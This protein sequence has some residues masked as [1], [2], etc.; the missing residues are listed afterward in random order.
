M[1]QMKKSRSVKL[2][3]LEVFRSPSPWRSLS[4][5]SKPPPLD[6]P[7]TEASSQKY[8][9][10]VRRLHN[11]MK[12]T[13]SSDAKKGLLPVSIQNTQSGSDGKNLPQKCLSNSSVSSKKPSKTL[14]RSSTLKPCS[15]YPIKSTIAVK[16][17]DVNPQEKATCSSTLK[18]SKFPTYLMLNPGGTESEGTSVM[19][20]CRYT[21]CSLNSHHHARLPQLNSFMSAR[22]RLLE[23]QKSVKLEAPKRLKV[24]CETK[25]ASDIDQVAFD[26]ELASDEADRGNPTP[27]LREIDMGFFIEIYAKEKQQAGRIGRFESVKHGEDQEDIMFAIE[28]NGKAAE[29]DGVKQAIPSVPH[30]LPKSETSIEED[31]KNYFDVAAIEE[32]AK[33]SLHQKQNAEVADKNHSP[34]WFHEE[35][36]MGSYFSEVS[37]DGEYMENIEL[38]DSD[39]QDTDMNW[40]EEQFSACDYKQEIDS[41][42]IMQKTGSKFEASSESLCGISEMWLD[43]I[44][45]NHYADILVEVAL[46]AVKEEK[47]THFE[48][49][50][51]GTK[52]V[53][54]DIEFNTQETDHLSN[55]ASHEHDQSSTEEVFEH[56]TNTRDNNRESEKHMDNEVS[57]ASKVLDEDAI[58][59]CEGHTNSETFAI[60]ESCEDSNPSLEI[61]DEGLSQENLINL[62]AEPKESSIIIQDQELLEE[63]QVRVS[64]FHTSCV[65]SE[66]QNTGKNWKWAV[67]HKRPDQDNEEVRRIN[68][69]KPNFLPLNPDPEPEK[70]DLKHQMIDERKHADEWM[71]DFA[72]RQAVTKLVPAG[73]MKVALLVE[74]FETVMS[75]PK[76]EAHIRNNS[77]FVHV[78]PIQA[79]S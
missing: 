77:P 43:D 35:I 4:Q 39:S 75:I 45:S 40:E 62:S 13:C 44:L 54:E 49:Q 37:Y 58:E 5:P 34:S 32:D 73:K 65:D 6:V 64:R 18:D 36:C 78:R 7:A 60:D 74:A 22:R 26:G 14:T 47:N 33:G 23:T 57:C 28:E 56:F 55:A 27:L 17:E 12:P 50:T 72:L 8:N 51:H 21:Y 69:R 31:L 66:Q 41:S 15:G 42:V 20:V 79:C 53:L 25:N 3:D 16:Q 76:C 9:P 71:L 46:Q 48:A 59:N 29:N 63:D 68:P 38:D 24:P 11:Y 30:D 1:K 61:N 52:S 19:K 2:S 10:S 67:R 70:V